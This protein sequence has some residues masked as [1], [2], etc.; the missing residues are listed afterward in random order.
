MTNPDY[1]TLL[2]PAH[3]AINLS[4]RPPAAGALER[5]Q[6]H[7]QTESLLEAAGAFGVADARLHLP[8]EIL[9]FATQQA[10]HRLY[11]F[12]A[13]DLAIL[14]QHRLRQQ[15]LVGFFEPAVDL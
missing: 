3:F 14:V 6:I 11:D 15:V 1:C 8:P 7:R 4:R 9:L 13:R 5:L 10:S 2:R 12:F